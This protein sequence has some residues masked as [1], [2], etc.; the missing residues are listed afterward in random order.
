MTR[1]VPVVNPH[2]LMLIWLSHEPRK[3]RIFHDDAG[4]VQG[5]I[6]TLGSQQNVRGSLDKTS[7]EEAALSRK[8]GSC[9]RCKKLKIKVSHSLAINHALTPLKQTL[10]IEKVQSVVKNLLR[11]LFVVSF[12]RALQK[13][14]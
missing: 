5:R 1:Y 11:A 10:P 7:R 2:T 8:C 9:E 6:M 14:T 13:H 12:L 4:R 3:D